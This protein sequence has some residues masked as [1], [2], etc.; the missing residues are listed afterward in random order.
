MQE[1]NEII[2]KLMTNLIVDLLLGINLFNNKQNE[3]SGKLVCTK[4]TIIINYNNLHLCINYLSCYS[5][6]LTWILII[7]F[8]F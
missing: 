8:S 7:L 3:M 4:P 6:L 5:Y 1:I 2:Y